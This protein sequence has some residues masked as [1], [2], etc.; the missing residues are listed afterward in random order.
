MGL[1]RDRAE[2]IDPR[3]STEVYLGEARFV[4]ELMGMKGAPL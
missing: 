4:K 2:T 1:L 3:R